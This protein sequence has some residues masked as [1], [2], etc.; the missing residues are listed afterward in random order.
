MAIDPLT[1]QQTF[2]PR[3]NLANA[4]LSQGLSAQPVETPIQ[5]LGRLAQALVGAK[6][7]RDARTEQAE[8]GERQLQ[9]LREALV[10]PQGQGGEQTPQNRFLAAALSSP[11]MFRTLGP[12]AIQSSIQPDPLTFEQQLELRRAGASRTNVST[13][14]GGEKKFSEETGK[15]TAQRLDDVIKTGRSAVGTQQSLNQAAD[16]L[17][18]G[19][20]STGTLQP[21]ITGLQGLAADLGVDIDSALKKANIRSLGSLQDK[22]EFDRLSKTVIIDG[23]EK[24]KG[25]LNDR[26]VRLALDAFSNLG[27]SEGANIKALASLKA[28]SQLAIERAQRASTINTREEAQQFENTFLTGDV[29]RFEELRKEFEADMRQRRENSAV[30]EGVDPEDFK[31]M[32]PEERA[33]FGGGQ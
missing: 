22:Q 8:Q 3:E 13:N 4:L 7:Q 17:V 31:F 20:V 6:L 32:T 18:E 14:V 23:F 10:G 25:N 24:F 1:G 28:S 5:G 19:G 9:G 12:A 16:L 26:E 27:K 30:P 33:L 15:L 21:A 11:E 2:D 29:E